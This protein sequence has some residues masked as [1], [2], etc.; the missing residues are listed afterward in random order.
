VGKILVVDD[1]QPVLHSAERTLRAAGHDVTLL[2]SS[3][4]CLLKVTQ[5]SFDVALVDYYMPVVDG[6]QVLQ[7]LRNLQPRCLRILMSGNLDLPVVLD[8]VNR[9]EVVRVLAKPFEP[10]QLLGLVADAVGARGR[11]EQ[12]ILGG[13][14]QLEG[15]TLEELEDCLNGNAL[16]LALQPIVHA[17]SGAPFA[18]EALLRSSD[19]KFPNPMAVLQSAERHDRIQALAMVVTARLVDWLK[20]LPEHAVLFMNMHPRELVSPDYLRQR[21]T[22]LSPWAK[23]VV[24]EITERSYLLELESWTASI[25]L[26]TEMGFAIAVDDLGSGYNSLSMLAELRPAFIKVDMSI[27]RDVN[28]DLRRRRLIELLARF[29][30]AT[31]AKL[32]AEGVETPEEAETLRECGT[33]LM[34]GYFFGR[35]SLDAPTVV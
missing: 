31:E 4:D 12:L 16:R 21:M 14:T 15:P 17:V 10:E 11:L 6:L 1:D 26:L 8:A 27:V 19:P 35:P 5:E 29:S 28:K 34:Q 23:R 2:S 9:G 20:R 30:N 33:D 7:R 32:I 24:L 25:G 3:L 18:F 13:S 22:V